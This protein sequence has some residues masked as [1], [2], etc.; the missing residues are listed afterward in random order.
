MNSDM[1]IRIIASSLPNMNSASACTSSASRR[2]SGPRKINEPIGR[3]GSFSRARARRT[4]LA[5]I[6]IGSS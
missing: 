5:T 2:R 1:S 3:R 6:V 4:A